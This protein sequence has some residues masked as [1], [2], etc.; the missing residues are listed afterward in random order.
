MGAV[1]LTTLLVFSLSSA[2]WQRREPGDPENH[3]KV[4][5]FMS[6]SYHIRLVLMITIKSTKQFCVF[7][8]VV[9]TRW[10][11]IWRCNT[12]SCH[13]LGTVPGLH[14]WK[15][16][17]CSVRFEPNRTVIQVF[18][19]VDVFFVN[20]KLTDGQCPPPKYQVQKRLNLQKVEKNK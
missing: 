12:L 15:L 7:K 8:Q 2:A 4:R 9:S 19:G 6:L 3:G 1:G 11:N 13:A 20:N 18:I 17:L 16:C 5:W 14:A 10:L